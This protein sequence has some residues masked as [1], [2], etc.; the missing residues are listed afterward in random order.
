MGRRLR[1]N[2]LWIF[3]L[4]AVSWNIKVYLHPH[5]AHDM[6]EFIARAAV[7]FVPGWFIIVT[8]VIFNVV[9]LVFAIATV[10]LREATGEVLPKHEFSL[11]SIGR[12]TGLSRV[13]QGQHTPRQTRTPT[14]QD[15]QRRNDNRRV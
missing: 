3:I 2:Y 13:A 8:G 1:R 6:D 4:L 10:R 12:V 15:R 14:R 11:R 9:L 7:G 5:P